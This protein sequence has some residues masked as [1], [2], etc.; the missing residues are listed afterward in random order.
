MV[1]SLALL[2]AV[3]AAL[4]GN[5]LVF[6]TWRR[7]NARLSR[8]LSVAS[9]AAFVISVLCC[10]DLFTQ[11]WVASPGS[12]SGPALLW[13]GALFLLLSA[14]AVITLIARWYGRRKAAA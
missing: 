14:S 9:L 5:I 12:I 13:P 8:S 3:F 2:S 11:V 7:Q 10:L 4:L 6:I 1:F